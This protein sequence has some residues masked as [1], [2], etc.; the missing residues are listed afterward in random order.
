MQ[1]TNLANLSDDSYA[2]VFF[3][4]IS[5]LKM[6]QTFAL[7]PPSPGLRPPPPPFGGVR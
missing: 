6:I 7:F 5:F 2:G 4:M 3:L 1:Y